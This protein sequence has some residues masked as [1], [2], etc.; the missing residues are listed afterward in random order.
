LYEQK[1]LDVKSVRFGSGEKSSG[2]TDITQTVKLVQVPFNFFSLRQ[3]FAGAGVEDVLA[4]L[5]SRVLNSFKKVTKNLNFSYKSH[6]FVVT[7]I[8][9]KEPSVDHLCL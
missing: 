7:G 3:L 8:Y 1:Y 5:R 4:R 2:S 6:N 9:F